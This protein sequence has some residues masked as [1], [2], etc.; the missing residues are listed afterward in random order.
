MALKPRSHRRDAKCVSG[1]VRQ[2]QSGGLLSGESVSLSPSVEGYGWSGV[3]AFLPS[4]RCA[5]HPVCVVHAHNSVS[6]WLTAQT[7]FRPSL[8]YMSIDLTKCSQQSLHVPF[9][10]TTHQ[11][12][13]IADNAHVPP[14]Y[15]RKS[16][17]PYPHQNALYPSVTVPGRMA[18]TPARLLPSK[19]VAS[20]QSCWPHPH[21][22]VVV[23]VHVSGGGRGGRVLRRDED[24]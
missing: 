5:L 6:D 13:H 2:R 4:S 9:P 8:E 7:S 1:I 17:S 15:L 22:V 23:V 24:R 18:G 20:G 12:I 16:D 10:L 11:T 3:T 19:R 21:V 14:T